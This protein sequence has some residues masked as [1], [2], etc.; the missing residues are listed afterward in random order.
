[1]PSSEKDKAR[2]EKFGNKLLS[3]IFVNYDQR[4]GGGWTGDVYVADWE[5]IENAHSIHDITPTRHNAK[6]VFPAK[7][8]GNSAFQ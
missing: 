6:E 5:Q 3:G 1:M 8:G 2:V 7:L 4:A